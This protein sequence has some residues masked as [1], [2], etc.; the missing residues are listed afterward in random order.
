MATVNAKTK[1]VDKAED[2]TESTREV[3]ASAEYN[4]PETLDELVSAFGPEVVASNA[5]NAIT[6]ALQAFMRRH[7]EKPA[8]EL[9]ALVSAWKPETR[10]AVVRK[11]AFEK[12][13]DAIGSLTPEQRKE[14]IAKLKAAA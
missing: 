5:A 11:S 6:I 4:I 13:N 10:A 3:S 7:I 9:Q 8:A 12:A 1:V 14:L 2:G